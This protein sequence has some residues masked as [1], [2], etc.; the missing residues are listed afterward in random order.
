MN[1]RRKVAAGILAAALGVASLLG[2]GSIFYHMTPA[3]GAHVAA[4]SHA[5]TGR[6]FYHM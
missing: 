6:I 2:V 4:A 1:L 5:N 3:G